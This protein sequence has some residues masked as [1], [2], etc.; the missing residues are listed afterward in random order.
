MNIRIF[1]CVVIILLCALFPSCS[2]KRQVD[3]NRELGIINKGSKITLDEDAAVLCDQ[4]EA[5]VEDVCDYQ[6]FLTTLLS[7]SVVDSYK[8]KGLYIDLSYK[9]KKSFALRGSSEPINITTIRIL[10]GEEMSNYIVYYPL[11]NVPK[12]YFLPTKYCEEIVSFL[13]IDLAVH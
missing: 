4:I 1:S 12:V 2:E 10:M 13:T 6:S 3:S 7:D 5:I 8:K 9:S 11:D